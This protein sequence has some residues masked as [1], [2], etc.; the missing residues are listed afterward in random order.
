MPT[1]VC[2]YGALLFDPWH[3]CRWI[4]RDWCRHRQLAENSTP[5][6]IALDMVQ[7][8]TGGHLQTFKFDI[9][10]ASSQ[11]MELY[12]AQWYLAPDPHQSRESVGAACRLLQQLQCPPAVERARVNWDSLYASRIHLADLQAALGMVWRSLH[13]TRSMPSTP[14]VHSPSRLAAPVPAPVR[15]STLLLAACSGLGIVFSHKATVPHSGTVTTDEVQPVAISADQVR[16]AVR[17]AT[18][19]GELDSVPVALLRI[20]VC[21]ALGVSRDDQALL[22]SVAGAT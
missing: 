19:Q 20:A 2:E 10:H 1:T 14:A 21:P 16:V 18:R 4:L 12:L 5:D 11:F 17:R 8:A 9:T 7:R 3:E 22:S 15:R 13:G 6:A